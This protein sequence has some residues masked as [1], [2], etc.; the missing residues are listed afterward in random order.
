[1]FVKLHF[2]IHLLVSWIS[3]SDL[4]SQIPDDQLFVGDTTKGHLQ[5]VSVEIEKSFYERV[6][7]FY[8]TVSRELQAKLPIAD[9]LLRSF[10]F[11][12]PNSKDA[13]E[14]CVK[15]IAKALLF[16]EDDISALSV[17]W[18]RYHMLQQVQYIYNGE[19][20]FLPFLD[21]LHYFCS[22][23]N[24]HLQMTL[25]HTGYLSHNSLME[26][27]VHVSLFCPEL[28]LH[29]LLFLMAMLR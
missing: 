10:R 14:D 4:T 1:L 12:D 3:F 13:S 24:W 26:M 18:R 29:V 22:V 20:S 2:C 9:P 16:S 27:V 19:D 23:R 17:E 15:T 25:W 8:V 5:K 11:I 7:R 28:P 21:F 6:R